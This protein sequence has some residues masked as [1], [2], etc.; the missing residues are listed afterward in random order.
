MWNMD[1]KIF[2]TRYLDLFF[3]GNRVP[4]HMDNL[5][6]HCTGFSSLVNYF[7]FQVKLYLILVSLKINITSN[8]LPKL[9]L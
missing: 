9:S 2:S 7:Y 6:F 3:P 5:M 1:E 4:I 8:N